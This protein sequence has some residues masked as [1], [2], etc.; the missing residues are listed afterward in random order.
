MDPLTLSMIIGG[1]TQAFKIGDGIIQKR[2]G[3]KLLEDNVRP[4]YNRPGEIDENLA[5]SRLG[6]SGIGV[7]GQDM[8]QQ[9]MDSTLGNLG[10]QAKDV[11]GSSA[12][13]LSALT[14]AY[15]NQQVQNR[16]LG[17]AGAEMQM[18]NRELLKESLRLSASYTDQEFAANEM[19]PFLDDAAAGGSLVNSGLTNVYSG[20]EGV[21]R[22]MSQGLMAKAM[23]GNQGE[24]NEA[25]LLGD[26][27]LNSTQKVGEA[28]LFGGN[29]SGLDP[30]KPKVA[31][32]IGMPDN[33]GLQTSAPN[34]QNQFQQ[35]MEIL[36]YIK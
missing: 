14:S 9:N 27:S 30:M 16:E 31:G 33:R 17:V 5:L 35:L 22:T 15:G 24:V 2:K 32:R 29:S 36:K 6:A 4:T 11:S 7:P 10:R 13:A 21:G 28:S 23:I 34:M 26:K 20:I 12:E 19:Q 25:P 18:K 1:A 3:N 8:I